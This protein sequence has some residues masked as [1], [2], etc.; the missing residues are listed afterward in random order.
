M[1]VSPQFDKYADTYDAELNQA[2]TVSGEDKQYFAFERVRW[3]ERCLQ[4]LGEQPSSAIDYGC[5]VGDTSAL[6]C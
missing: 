6:L 5:G 2:L 1:S 4:E 3:L